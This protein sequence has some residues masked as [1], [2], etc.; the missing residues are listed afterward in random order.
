M[1]NGRSPWDM[2]NKRALPSSDGS[3]LSQFSDNPFFTAGLGLAGFGAVLAAGQ[4]GG[5]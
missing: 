4:R 5:M 2:D 1:D 3:F